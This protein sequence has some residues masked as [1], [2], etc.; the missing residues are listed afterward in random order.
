MVTGK[1]WSLD[2][3]WI[4]TLYLDAYFEDALTKMRADTG[5]GSTF[6]LFTALNEYFY[7]YGYM[8]EKGYT[9]H[10]EKYALPLV[11]EFEHR[12]TLENESKELALRQKELEV[13]KLSKPRPNYT[14]MS[15]SELQKEYNLAKNL[16]D[17]TTLQLIIFEFKKR[18]VA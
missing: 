10:K 9:Y 8:E 1:S 11:Q 17:N 18:G 15:I 7:E 5:L 13:K 4:H 12:L 14:K 3:S 16:G 2:R 6:S